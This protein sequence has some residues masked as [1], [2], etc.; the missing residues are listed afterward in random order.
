MKQFRLT[1]FVLA[2][3]SSNIIFSQS[4]CRDAHLEMA[5]A[6][7]STTAT[8]ATSA[9]QTVT[10][11]Q[12]ANNPTGNTYTAYSP[13]V[14]AMYSLASP[15]YTSPINSLVFGAAVNGTASATMPLASTIYPTMNFISSAPAAS[16]TRPAQLSNGN[17]Y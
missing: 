12:N 16:F 11:S 15:Q 7:M 10:F 13:T 3:L 6:G 17:G 1:L 9:N 8:G 4:V 14:T 2:I 5:T